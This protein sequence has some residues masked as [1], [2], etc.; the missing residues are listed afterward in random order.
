MEHDYRSAARAGASEGGGES[1]SEV[2]WQRLSR[3]MHTQWRARAPTAR[4]VLRQADAIDAEHIPAGEKKILIANL[5]SKSRIAR[6]AASLNDAYRSETSLIFPSG[7]RSGGSASS[8]G[9]AT[10]VS[11][12]SRS[13]S[14]GSPTLAENGSDVLS[15]VG[16]GFA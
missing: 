15:L 5:M 12:T 10:K 11:C 14:S 16:G 1:Q 7:S 9:L 13:T 2:R 3:M 6:R 8:H 4:G